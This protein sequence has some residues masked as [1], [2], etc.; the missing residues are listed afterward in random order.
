MNLVGSY[1]EKLIPNPIGNQDEFN[2]EW[3]DIQL[4]PTNPA[5]GNAD[6]GFPIDLTTDPISIPDPLKIVMENIGSG[7][8]ELKDSFMYLGVL[9]KMPLPEAAVFFNN[10][11]DKILLYFEQV[12]EHKDYPEKEE[13]FFQIGEDYEKLTKLIHS[14]DAIKPIYENLKLMY[15]NMVELRNAGIDRCE[16]VR[17]IKQLFESWK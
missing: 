3:D 1:Q 17:S 12:W 8:S 7:F 16:A 13:V 4:T 15:Q 5:L 6:R 9:K 10:K 11:F 14:G 2:V